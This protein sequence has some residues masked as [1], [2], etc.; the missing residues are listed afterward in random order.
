LK[1]GRSANISS[2]KIND[3][4]YG[5]F[6]FNNQYREGLENSQNLSNTY[7][8]MVLSGDNEGERYSRT[9]LPKG[10]ELIFNQKPEQN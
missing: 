2:I 4:Y 3:V 6:I 7:Q 9:T 8:I 1:G 5:K 10:T